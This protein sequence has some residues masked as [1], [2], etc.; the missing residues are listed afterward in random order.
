MRLPKTSGYN[1]FISENYATI[2]ARVKAAFTM[3]T[4]SIIPST[5][6]RA[7]QN[8]EFMRRTHAELGRLWQLLSTDQRNASSQ[9]YYPSFSL[10][11]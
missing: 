10:N 11:S 2:S 5:T 6:S 8:Q 3:A 4:S 7:R 9:F 1:L